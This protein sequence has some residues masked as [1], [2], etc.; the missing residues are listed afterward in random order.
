[1]IICCITD[2]RT[3]DV[4]GC[5][6]DIALLTVFFREVVYKRRPEQ[7]TTDLLKEKI[8]EY[9]ASIHERVVNRGGVTFRI[10]T[11]WSYAMESPLN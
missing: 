3:F 6:E 9:E 1:M 8:R 4:R 5:P 11:L 7:I 2:G 10:K